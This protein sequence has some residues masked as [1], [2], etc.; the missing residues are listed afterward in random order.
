MTQKVLGSHSRIHTQSEPWILLHPL[1][2][3]VEDGSHARHTHHQLSVQASRAFIASL[4]GGESRYRKE[5]GEAYARM[6][7]SVLDVEGKDIF[8]DKTPRYYLIA[9]ELPLFFPESPIIC[10]L[11]NPLAVLNSVM[12]T[13]V[14]SN[15]SI[16]TRY[17]QDLLEAPLIFRDLM[18]GSEGNFVFV[19]YEDL[20]DDPELHFNRL[21]EKLG[22]AFEPAMINYKRNEIFSFGD[23]E[24]VDRLDRP[25]TDVQDGWIRGLENPQLW[26]LQK[27]YL[28][29]LGPETV[30]ALGYDPV[31]LKETILSFSP[32]N[33]RLRHT[34]SLEKLMSNQKNFRESADLRSAKVMMQ[35][36]N[37]KGCMLR[38]KLRF[39]KRFIQLPR[40]LFRRMIRTEEKN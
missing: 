10:L 3:L 1:H 20:V 14:K 5:L 30:S 23:Q 28:E 22:L 11:R 31:L 18:E 36:P 27:E 16:L 34:V 39:L 13:W 38:Q 21:C 25:N 8:L 29:K 32:S 26:R 15:L 19:R 7:E 9:R 6:Y 2:A 35:Q 12:S 33:K 40:R 37:R 24:S 4:P 17:R